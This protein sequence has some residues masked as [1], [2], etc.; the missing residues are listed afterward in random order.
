MLI[1]D[2]TTLARK[3]V[4]YGRTPVLVV[5]LASILISCSATGTQSVENEPAISGTPATAVAEPRIAQSPAPATS[6]TP[7]FTPTAAAPATADSQLDRSDKFWAVLDYEADY[8]IYETLGEMTKAADLV[9]VGHV[10]GIDRSRTAGKPID[11]DHPDVSVLNFVTMSVVID[12]TVKGEA[13][14]KEQGVIAVEE[15]IP[16][17]GRF[18]ELAPNL[19]SES[20][21]F[22]L[23][24]GAA[25]AA[26]NGHPPAY[27]EQWLYSYVLLSP[28]QALIRNVDGIVRVRVGW[29]Y[30]FPNNID[31]TSFDELLSKTRS[32]AQ[33][34]AP[35]LPNPHA[36]P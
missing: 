12:E 32:I 15:L 25:A 30:P 31:G 18:D 8:P 11:S 9:V 19:P 21:L 24:N 36:T 27:Q 28:P 35:E 4:S 22:F 7:S 6:E 10:T 20:A 2:Q 33:A 13:Q 29:H 5:V 23:Q 34:V 16:N 1:I 14:S 17:A 3:A 26:R